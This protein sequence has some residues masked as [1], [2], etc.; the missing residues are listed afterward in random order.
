MSSGRTVYIKTRLT[1]RHTKC[2]A[3]PI[4]GICSADFIIGTGDFCP[5]K[6]AVDMDCIRY[7]PAK[8]LDIEGGSRHVF[9]NPVKPDIN[10]AA[11]ST[12]G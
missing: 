7:L 8:G 1:H 9:L 3:A 2:D 4:I 12:R 10:P 11:N 6:D 5:E